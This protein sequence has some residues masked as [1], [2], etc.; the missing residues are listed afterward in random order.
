MVER[1][2]IGPPRSL[3]KFTT[4]VW[5]SS[6]LSHGYCE[7]PGARS[8]ASR[9]V[10]FPAETLTASGPPS[11]PL[12]EAGNHSGERAL[13]QQGCTLLEPPTTTVSKGGRSPREG[14]EHLRRPLLAAQ[15]AALVTPASEAETGEGARRVTPHPH[16]C[17]PGIAV[18]QP[19]LSE[20][21]V[22]HA[23]S[24]PDP[25]TAGIRDPIPH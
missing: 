8:L 23:P 7:H 5:R 10:T 16:L 20:P 22:P 24:R 3:A 11:P 4:P 12:L 6:A 18:P 17:Y 15:A 14:P 21:E 13:C 19:S 25:E 1:G 9:G 2:D